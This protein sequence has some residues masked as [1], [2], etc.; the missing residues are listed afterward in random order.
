MP[1]SHY[2]PSMSAVPII[3]SQ[4]APSLRSLCR[5]VIRVTKMKDQSPLESGWQSESVGCSYRSDVQCTCV[6]VS[7]RV[8]VL[9]SALGAVCDG[10]LEV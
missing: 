3:A 8:A 5:S 1:P 4:K 9:S 6:S 2:D 10:A 7:V